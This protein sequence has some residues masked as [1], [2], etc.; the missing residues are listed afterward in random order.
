M[1][2][3]AARLFL[4]GTFGQILLVCAT[5]CILR[6]NGVPVDFTNGI[7]M[8]AI[9]AGGTS[10]ALWGIIVSKQCRGTSLREIFLDF[11][12]LNVS[13]RCYIAVFLFL[14]VD[15]CSVWVGGHMEITYWYLPLVLFLKAILFGGIEEIGWRYTFQPIM[16]EKLQFIPAT[17]LTFLCWGTWHFLYFYIEGTLVQ[18][19]IL[20]FLMGLLTNCFAL[21]AL[22]RYSGSLWVCVMTHALINTLSLIS[23]GGNEY[24]SLFC[25]LAIIGFTCIYAQKRK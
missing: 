13:Y 20:P 2:K 18:V 10:S 24:I 14:C 12:R 4:V 6:K 9:A 21:A 11:F 25:K 15:F 3:N 17:L 5:V 16:E 22:Y 7:G 1:T 23:I 8:A 19:Q